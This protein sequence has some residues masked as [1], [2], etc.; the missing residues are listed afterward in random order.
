MLADSPVR[1]RA[2]RV[3][4]CLD[5]ETFVEEAG[6]AEVSTALDGLGSV[7]TDLGIGTRQPETITA[8]RG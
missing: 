7:P 1:I 3:P 2:R 4:L 8:L 5:V 6:E